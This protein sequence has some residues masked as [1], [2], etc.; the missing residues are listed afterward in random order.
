MS[1]R[2]NKYPTFR[3]PPKKNWS[4]K[5]IKITNFWRENLRWKHSCLRHFQFIWIKNKISELF[6]KIKTRKHRLPL[7][8][9]RSTRNEFPL[10]FRIYVI[11]ANKVNP[12]LS[13]SKIQPKRGSSI[14][15]QH[16]SKQSNPHRH[17]WTIKYFL[18][19]INELSI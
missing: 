7:F 17:K 3:K 10:R 15:K 16:I 12:P 11:Q 14:T 5:F 2:I 9:N 1:K 8:R 19:S 13:K 18:R 6:P 4:F